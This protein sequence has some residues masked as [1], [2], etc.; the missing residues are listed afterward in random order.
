MSVYSSFKFLKFETK[1]IDDT[2]WEAYNMDSVAIQENAK[3]WAQRFGI[4]TYRIEGNDMIY[5]I[6]YP[7]N[8]MTGVKKY[9]IQHIIN[10]ETMQ[11]E[12]MKPLKKFDKLA[13]KN[14]NDK[15]DNIFF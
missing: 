4:V 13:L 14:N 8:L 5:N 11:Q 3:V 1:I 6:S 9:T 7:T 10:L 12:T 2:A 15:C